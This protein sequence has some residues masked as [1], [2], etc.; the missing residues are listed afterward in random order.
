[1]DFSIIEAH[2]RKGA[3]ALDLARVEESFDF[4]RVAHVARVARV[5]DDEFEGDV[6]DARKLLHREL[7]INI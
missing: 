5:D 7:P 1:L 4:A 2:W 3:H 6:R